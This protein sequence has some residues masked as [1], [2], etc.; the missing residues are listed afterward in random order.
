VPL[1]T[2]ELYLVLRARDEASRVMGN[3]AHNMRSM[4]RDAVRA[5]QAQMA[6]G[7]ALATLGV[8]LA[9][10]GAAGL[11]FFKNAVEASIE[12]NKQAA[13]TKTQTDQVAVSIEELKAISSDVASR[14]PAP[15]E[16]L[17]SSLYD[18]FSSIDVNVPEAK[19]L[20]QE[21]AKASVAGQTDIQVAGRAT[22]AVL[23][24]FKMPIKDVTRVNDIM[25][26]LVRKGVGTYEEFTKTIGRAIPSTARAGQSFETL[27]G[28][29]AFLTR[30]GLST[31]MAAT[32]AARAMD[33]M[34]NPKTAQHFKDIGISVRDANGQFR[35]M[36][37]IMTDLGKK[38][39]K[40]TKPERA[41]AL[42]ELFL[43]S[44]G[45]IQAR[46]FFDLAITN[47]G[48]LNQRTK[49]MINSKG[50]MQD[51]YDVMFKQ[52]V[53]Q[54]QLFKNNW[55]VLKTAM[56][57]AV[58]PILGAVAKQFA[59]L[60][61]WFNRLSPSTKKYIAI[62][63]LIISVLLVLTGIVVSLV[64]LWLM[65]SAAMT[66]AG[67]AIGP[68]IAIIAGIVLAIIAIGVAI[69]FIIKYHKQIWAFMVSVWNAIWNFLVDLWSKIWTV[70]GPYVMAIVNGFMTAWN[71]VWQFVTVTIPQIWNTIS[72]A[73]MTGYNFIAGVLQT[74]WS[75][76]TAIWSEVW[77]WIG[78][79]LKA[80]WA[81]I[82]AIF[83]AV[84]AVVKFY[85]EL[86]MLAA[87]FYFT[88]V[89]TIIK[90]VFTTIWKFLGPILG[91]LWQ[92]IRIAFQLAWAAVKL[93]AE[94]MWTI[95][96][97]V[98]NA[99]KS[100]TS[101][102]W[103]AIKKYIIDPIR[104][105]YNGAKTHYTNLQKNIT[106]VFTRVKSWFSSTWSKMTS[107]ITD[108]IRNA[109]N[110]IGGF[111]DTIK[112]KIEGF[113]SK[114][115]APLDKARDL[116]SKL[117]PAAHFS[118]SVVDR[119]RWGWQD[120]HKVTKAGMSNVLSLAQG[121][122][123]KTRAATNFNMIPG[124]AFD[125]PG[126]PGGYRPPGFGPGAGGAGPAPRP[127]IEIKQTINTQEIDPAKHAADLGWEVARRLGD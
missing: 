104:D 54:M 96:K 118:P 53:S 71:A 40:L 83:T 73:F 93:Y 19:L 36:N 121:M 63:L 76:F 79:V 34:S 108:P 112:G 27:A 124:A 59:A 113:V 100:F 38:M 24:A 23:N 115:T 52:P 44:G 92:L 74:I 98:F 90:F 55:M 29:M 94:A 68:V 17:Q 86:V 82:K 6:K 107:A 21:F 91:I 80:G 122:A 20:L 114:I 8:G 49:E 110:T 22:I 11:A 69:F 120:M 127:S 65:F 87:K 85:L 101:T 3:M 4:D 95:I 119:A 125:G 84:F 70:I 25:F 37:D 9:I 75:V 12:Y 72:N 67:V 123:N 42:H 126:L 46:R 51:A 47:Y 48:E 88:T 14:I 30:N 50:A 13:L 7:R 60:L 43:G 35:P 105:A 31:A 78:P 58:L 77:F 18:I 103:N 45:T 28:M 111:L 10:A 15:F 56:G 64:G 89:W 33:A 62:T 116:L 109:A 2:R 16:S 66:L 81:V 32:S 117:N 5:A 39:A 57:D 106:D 61:N 26:Q 97:V 1:N 102:A 99:I 41:K